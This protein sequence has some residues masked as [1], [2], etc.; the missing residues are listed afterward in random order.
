MEHAQGPADPQVV[1]RG[2][3]VAQIAPGRGR[4]SSDNWDPLRVWDT[5]NP[6]VGLM[7]RPHWVRQLTQVHYSKREWK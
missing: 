2:S 1:G 4:T 7:M 6:C 3:R 5:G